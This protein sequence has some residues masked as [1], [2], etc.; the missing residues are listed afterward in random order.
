MMSIDEEFFEEAVKAYLPYVD[1]ATKILNR[2]VIVEAK[3]VRELHILIDERFDKVESEI[4]SIKKITYLMI[5]LLVSFIS[6]ASTF[7]IKNLF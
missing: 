7:F 6:I 3:T 5:S 4:K 1:L 2:V